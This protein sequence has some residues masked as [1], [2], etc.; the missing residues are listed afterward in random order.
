MGSAEWIW[1]ARYRSGATGEKRQV[2]SIAKKKPET[3]KSKKPMFTTSQKKGAELHGPPMAGKTKKAR[4]ENN[5]SLRQREN[6]LYQKT[7][8]RDN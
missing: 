1:G 8:K 3:Q 2:L 7:K 6:A 4:I 5:R